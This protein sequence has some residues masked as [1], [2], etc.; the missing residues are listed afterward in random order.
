M[1][2]RRTNRPSILSKKRS[3]PSLNGVATSS[4]PRGRPWNGDQDVLS[5]TST[6]G[7]RSLMCSHEFNR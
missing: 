7:S 4:S 3:Q 6:S 1:F 2:L 5:R